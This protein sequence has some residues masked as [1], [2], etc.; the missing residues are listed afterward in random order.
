M[1]ES[2]F[3]LDPSSVCRRPCSLLPAQVTDAFFIA[4]H[5]TEFLLKL[6]AD[7]IA[8]WKSSY[9]TLDAAILLVAFLPHALPADTAARTHLEV[10]G[11]QRSPDPPHTQA[12]QV[13]QRDEGVTQ[14]CAHARPC[15]TPG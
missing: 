1:D 2:I 13:R 3:L 6:Y 11:L 8:Y 14:V 15:V 7:P 12:H 4:I 9:N 5:T 10:V